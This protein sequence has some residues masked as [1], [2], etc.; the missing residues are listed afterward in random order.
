MLITALM[1]WWLKGTRQTPLQAH[2]LLAMFLAMSSFVISDVDESSSAGGSLPTFAVVCVMLKVAVSCY[3]A[4]LAEKYLKSFK[5]MP[6]YAKISAL[7][8]TW[9]LA[10]AILCFATERKV[11]ADGFYSHWTTATCFV[12]V[13]FVVK[14]LSTQYLL[15]KLDSVQKNIGE[16][17]SVIVIYASQVWLPSFDKSFNL[18]VFLLAILVVALVKT[19]L[20][21]TPTPAMK[22]DMAKRKSAKRVNIVKLNPDGTQLMRT[23]G[24]NTLRCE[25]EEALPDGVFYGM[26]GGVHPVCGNT[27]PASSRQCELMMIGEPASSTPL[28]DSCSK[29]PHMP[30]QSLT[31]LGHIRGELP[32]ESLT[33]KRFEQDVECATAGIA[34]LVEAD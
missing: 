25:V 10:S 7:S 20:L 29:L 22:A 12:V 30:Q 32:K 3:C 26:L 28:T 2:V 18:G 21:S 17:L 33:A 15:Q 11:L 19:Y 31:V 23:L 24:R 27:S 8:T 5:Q 14:T 34:G 16:A 6:F 4:V 9:A 13:S 1:L